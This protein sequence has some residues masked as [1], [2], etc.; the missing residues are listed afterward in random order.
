MRE[1]VGEGL[2]MHEGGS[3]G[4][5]KDEGGVSIYLI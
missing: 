3:E 5:S 2:G 1:S 4:K